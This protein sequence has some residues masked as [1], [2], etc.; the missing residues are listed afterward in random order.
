M[1]EINDELLGRLQGYIHWAAEVSWHKQRHDAAKQKALQKLQKH[2]Y[3]DKL[4][5]D[6]L[7]DIHRKQEPL[8]EQNAAVC[9][10]IHDTVNA[11]KVLLANTHTELF[12]DNALIAAAQLR[13]SSSIVYDCVAKQSKLVKAATAETCDDFLP[14]ILFLWNKEKAESMKVNCTV[15]DMAAASHKVLTHMKKNYFVRLKKLAAQQQFHQD[16][17]QIFVAVYALGMC[18]K[19]PM[20]LTG[21]SHPE[22][23]NAHVS[24]AKTVLGI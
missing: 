10:E 7:V 24:F 19:I 1:E 9:A 4:L 11:I 15:H 8:H 3:Y 20:I 14:Q 21:I 12:V 17:Q 23:E 22:V 5:F 6:T 16:H 18:S 2:P 13:D